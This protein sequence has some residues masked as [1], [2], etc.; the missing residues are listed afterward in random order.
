MCILLA[1]TFTPT[2]SLY[3]QFFSSDRPR[4]MMKLSAYSRVDLSKTSDCVAS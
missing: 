4:V 1:Q 3:V 2:H